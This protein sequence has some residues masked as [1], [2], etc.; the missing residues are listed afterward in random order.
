MGTKRAGTLTLPVRLLG[1]E[2]TSANKQT[3]YDAHAV[4]YI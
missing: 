1:P 2:K 4:V 3:E